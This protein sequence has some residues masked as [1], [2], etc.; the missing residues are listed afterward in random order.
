[1]SVSD[2]ICFEISQIILFYKIDQAYTT[3]LGFYTK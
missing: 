2:V 1:M 3:E